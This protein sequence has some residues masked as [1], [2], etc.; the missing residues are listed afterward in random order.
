[1]FSVP[2][3]AQC[4][5][6]HNN[7]ISII[8]VLWNLIGAASSVVVSVGLLYVGV[9]EMAVQPLPGGLHL[10]GL[11]RAAETSVREKRRRTRF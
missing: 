4:S 3:R 5:Q 7:K 2:M 8:T 6:R 1:V 9:P 11:P 10:K